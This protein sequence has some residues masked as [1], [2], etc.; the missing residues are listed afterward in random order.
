[1]AWK[2]TRG[3]QLGAAAIAL[4]LV[5]PPMP[6]RV[7]TDF[8]LEPGERAEIRAAVPGEISEVRVR[9]GDFVQAGAIL[10]FLHN[11]EIEARAIIVEHDL[12]LAE[13]RMRA[14]ESRAS[15]DEIAKAARE[16]TRLR[17]DLS[18]AQARLNGLTVRARVAG[19]VTT[20]E[21]EQRVGE[22]VS[23]GDSVLTVVN[24]RTMR[25][26]ILVRDWD[27]QQVKEG[28]SARL[29]VSSYPF[30]TFSGRVERILPAAALD[31]PV[32]QPEKVERF[33]QELTNYFA[34]VLEFPNPDDVL[35]EG[36]TGTAKI[37]GHFY[38]L[39]W[40]AGRSI[41]RWINTQVW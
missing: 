39:A 16:A 22:Y 2:I 29:K 12:A 26:R 6:S 20:A 28:A 21:V 10:I 23:E 17:E 40:Q 30:R 33:G 34:V 5:V 15:S 7:A 1:M 27:L 11:P 25:A 37:S 41:W 4:L 8:V 24:R 36:M 14:A 35:R 18:V 3:Q 9:Q 19:I 13:G 31:R 38:P 32:A